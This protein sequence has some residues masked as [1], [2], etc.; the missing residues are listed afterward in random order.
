MARRHG[1]PATAAPLNSSKKNPKIG[2]FFLLRI[3]RASEGAPGRVT[4][5]RVLDI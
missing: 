5:H 1:A 4:A 2:D 3:Q